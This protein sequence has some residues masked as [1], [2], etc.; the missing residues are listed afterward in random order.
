M[1]Y[2][3]LNKITIKNCYLLLLI[4]ELMEWISKAKYFTKLDMHNGYNQL[5]MALGEEW[6]KA[7]HCRYGL[8]EYM[9]MPFGLWNVLS[10]F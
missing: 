5:Q 8:Y 10:T 7:F 4:G 2:R 3:G 6:K 9:V 1:N